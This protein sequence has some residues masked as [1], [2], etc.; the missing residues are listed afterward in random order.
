M[1]TQSA[2]PDVPAHFA[3]RMSAFFGG[4]FLVQ[5]VA[6]PW[7]PV[8]LES[9][10]MSDV[11]IASII[12]IPMAF[13]FVILPLG[14]IVADRT[15]TRRFAVRLFVTPAVLIFLLAATATSYWPLLLLTGAAF[16]LWQ[17]ALPGGEALAL[18]GVRRFGIDYG[19]MRLWGS[20]AFIAANVGSGALLS[21]L[22][23][24]AIFWFIFLAFVVAAV[25]AIALPMTPR[26][27]RALDDASRPQSKPAWRVI[28]HPSVLMPIVAG[29]LIQGSHAL[30]YSFGSIYWQSLGYSPLQI[31]GFWAT[32]IACEVLLF[33]WSGAIL[34]RIG[35][36]AML[37]IGAVAAIVRWSLFPADL[38]G[39]GYLALQCLHGL[40]F[41]AV[42]L[43]NQFAVTRAVPEEMA[44]SAQSVVVLAAGLTM[45]GMT[46]LSGP[47]YEAFGAAAFPMMVALPIASLILLGVL[48][49]F[50]KPPDGA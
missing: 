31:G 1:T 37:A 46:A 25:T 10:G 38:G 2:T 5:G 50:V 20:V 32:S 47:L 9:R 34:R 40:T 42:F 48:K 12:A 16:A 43:G 8:W 3:L 13:R 18:T 27:V 4:F 39:F 7:F 49:L 28:G 15:P 41:G 30:F 22:P 6:I 35:P 33:V 14:G 26:A 11:E 36:L 44:A 23:T 19:R 24:S 29:G 45:A 17:L 21:F